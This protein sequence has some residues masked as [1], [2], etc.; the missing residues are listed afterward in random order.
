LHQFDPVAER[1]VNIAAQH[2]GEFVVPQD[3]RAS[4]F[5]PFGEGAKIIDQQGRMGLFSGLEPGFDAKVELDRP[6]CEP[7]P[8]ARGERRR[9]GHFA[10]PENRSVEPPRGIL[11]AGRH[12]E[13]DMIETDYL[14]HI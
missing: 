2:A 4:L 1:V 13:L 9:F 10:E 5:D 11:A 12:C 6:S 7:A 3:C 14:H 8:A